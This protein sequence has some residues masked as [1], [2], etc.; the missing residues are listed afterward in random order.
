MPFPTSL[1]T[2]SYPNSSQ[3]M[4]DPAVLQTT[5]VWDLNNVATALQAKVWVD[6]SAVTT[7]L[8]YKTSRLTTK[9][10][11]L[12]H[13]WT[14]PI[15]IATWTDG[16]MLISDSTKATW[17]D[18]IAPTS[19]GTVTSASV[20]SANWLAWTV[21]TATTTPA[22]TLST[23]VT[24][25]LKGNWTAIS[26][27]SAWTD[28]SVPTGVETLTNKTLTSPAI[29]SPTITNPTINVGSDANG[30]IYTRAWGT[31]ARKAI[32]TTW[33]FLTVSG[34]AVA[35]ANPITYTG[36]LFTET[37]SK[38]WTWTLA[39][40]SNLMAWLTTATV[41]LHRGTSGYSK[42]EYS[43]DNA[44]WTDII[45]LS[46]G[47]SATFPILLKKGYYYRCT[48]NSTVG[49]DPTTAVITYIY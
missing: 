16:Y 34:W 31:L 47:W 32:G 9:G 19:G 29:N 39:G 41:S 37:I 21:A 24:G 2:F 43:P 10:D 14:N 46:T 4:D 40:T 27:A 11:I 48:V 18:W 15:K 42:L 35:W 5:I 45:N 6:N 20:V 26:A 23:T 44:A 22:I 30:D 8:D 33:D 17:H 49:G 13:D 28:Y 25:L 1:D 12:T 36:T 3:Y 7:S 38:D